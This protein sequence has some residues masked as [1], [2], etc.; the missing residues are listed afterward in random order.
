[1]MHRMDVLKI[2]IG[3]RMSLQ[4]HRSTVMVTG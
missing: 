2:N 4:I 1:M 3:P